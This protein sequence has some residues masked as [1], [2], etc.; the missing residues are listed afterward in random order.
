MVASLL[1]PP[2]SLTTSFGVHSGLPAEV[3]FQV[4]LH[5]NQEGK[6]CLGRFAS[7][8]FQ[9]C[10]FNLDSIAFILFIQPQRL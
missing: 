8:H 2:A 6:S 9:I 1:V 3:Y 10:V 4:R 5:N 7:H